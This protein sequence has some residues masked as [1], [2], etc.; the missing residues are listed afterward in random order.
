MKLQDGQET[1]LRKNRNKTE[2]KTESKEQRRHTRG[3]K[4]LGALTHYPERLNER[5]TQRQFLLFLSITKRQTDGGRM[6]GEKILK[7]SVWCQPGVTVTNTA[8]ISLRFYPIA[9]ENTCFPSAGRCLLKSLSG[10]ML[11]D[12]FSTWFDVNLKERSCQGNGS[13]SRRALC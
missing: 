12:A 13:R 7:A 8:E 2:K 5:E 10:Q 4:L 9:M 1:Q 3:R 6:M 11:D